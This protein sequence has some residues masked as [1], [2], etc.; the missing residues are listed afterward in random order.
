[1]KRAVLQSVVQWCCGCTGLFVGEGEHHVLLL[2]HPDPSPPSTTSWRNCLFCTVHSCLLCHRLTDHNCVVYRWRGQL[3]LTQGGR[4]LPPLGV[5]EQAPLAAP[6]T[7]EDT[8]EEGFVTKHHL[9]L[10]S[11][12][13]ELTHPTTATA[14]CSQHHLNLPGNLGLID[15]NYCIW[16][17]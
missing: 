9:L 5:H 17:G 2:C 16:N 13:W 15:A 1:M 8:T 11:L 3:S 4:G 12:P 7:S 14:K 10:L 6:V